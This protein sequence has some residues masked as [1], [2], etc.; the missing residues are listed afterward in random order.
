[1]GTNLPHG[2][3]SALVARVQGGSRVGRISDVAVDRVRHLVTDDGELV[4][5]QLALVVALGVS[6]CRQQL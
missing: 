6:V 4:K 3:D 1:M 5:L 2:I